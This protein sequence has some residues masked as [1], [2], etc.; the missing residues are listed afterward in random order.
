MVFV[1][2]KMEENQSMCI[3]KSLTSI[4]KRN[5]SSLAKRAS[6]ILLLCVIHGEKHDLNVNV[7]PRVSGT[8]KH[9]LLVTWPG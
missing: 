8:T 6:H 1:L 4:N 2:C 3:Q 9:R 7:S 5:G